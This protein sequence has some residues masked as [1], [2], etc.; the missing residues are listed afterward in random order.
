MPKLS[1]VIPAVNIFHVSSLNPYTYGVR[2][3][4]KNVQ[5][6]QIPML[7]GDLWIVPT[8]EL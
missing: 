3:W 7:I 8:H 5:N 6:V 2:K 1:I 4:L